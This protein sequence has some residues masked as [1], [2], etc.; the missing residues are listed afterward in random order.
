MTRA[1]VAAALAAAAFASSGCAAVHSYDA[2]RDINPAR[3]LSISSSVGTTLDDRD[4]DGDGINDGWRQE[5]VL[6]PDAKLNVR[7]NLN[8]TMAVAI[9]PLPPG[10]GGGFVFRH[11]LESEGAPTFTL[12]PVMNYL[13]FPEQHVFSVEVPLAL[14]RKFGRHFVLY[15]GPKYVWQSKT[16]EPEEGVRRLI[17][18]GV[19]RR[20]RKPLEFVGGF[21][22]FGFG[23]LHVQVSPEVLFY[24]SLDDGERVLQVGSQIRFAL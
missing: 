3:T 1:C 24:Q 5:K 11:V 23:F 4:R 20:E 13:V 12:A 16:L 6:V 14:S 21:A 9:D 2:P 22:G 8:R 7:V 17:L 10:I 18:F 19:P 15:A